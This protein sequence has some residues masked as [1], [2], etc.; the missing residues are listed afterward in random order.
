MSAVLQSPP[1][2]KME[3]PAAYPE[4][5]YAGVSRYQWWVLVVASLGWIF[6]VFEGQVFVSSEKQII[7]DLAPSGAS[8]ADIAYYSNVMLATF[9]LGGALGGVAFGAVSDRIG[10]TRTMVYTILTYSLFT[11]VSALAQ[12]W[13]QFAILRFL[14]AMGVGGEWAVASAMVAEVFPMQARARSLGIF[15]ASSVLGT[16]LATAAGLWVTGNELWGWRWAFVVGSAPALLTLA[17]RFSLREPQAWLEA[18][19]AAIAGRGQRLGRVRELFAPGMTG[20]TLVGVAL[21]TVGM[22]TFW[23][24]HIHGREVLMRDHERAYLL[25]YL[26]GNHAHVPVSA[27]EHWS[28]GES[29]A[30]VR[31]DESAEQSLRRISESRRRELLRHYSTQ[32]KSWEMLGMLIVTTGG[33]LGLLA[34]GPLA[35]RLGRRGAF[36]L[37]QLGGLASSLWVFLAPEGWTLG[38]D[39]VQLVGLGGFGF[40]TLGMHAGFAIYFPELFPTRLRGTGGGFCFNAGRVLAAPT[41]LVSGWLRTD[42]DMSMEQA[43]V[44]L[45]GLFVLGIVLLWFAPET[46]GQELPA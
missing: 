12:N 22:A 17:I 32:F 10:R 2:L 28:G 9:L 4:P 3:Q 7:P 35:E 29:E 27:W 25:Q 36:L 8:S 15:H 39:L 20:R 11:C 16:Y 33:G 18:R 41:L 26:A 40:L 34:F 19:Q 37:F 30:I 44:W 1:M 5:W 14:V 43:A 42:W 46:K 31:I 23:G 38:S 24:V 6:D 13:W 45:S 21:A